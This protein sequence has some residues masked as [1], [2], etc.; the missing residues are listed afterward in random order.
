MLR[1]SDAELR[2]EATRAARQHDGALAYALLETALRT[3]PWTRNVHT[4]LYVYATVRAA[5]ER[6][7]DPRERDATRVFFRGL[8]AEHL[9]AALMPAGAMSLDESALLRAQT[10]EPT[11]E[12]WLDMSTALDDLCVPQ[13]L[14]A[15]AA[16][17]HNI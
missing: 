3:G 14:A 11:L 12:R 16:Q 9:L 1:Y 13:L 17:L 15:V 6:D 2:T 4:L 8:V 10:V 7:L 5:L